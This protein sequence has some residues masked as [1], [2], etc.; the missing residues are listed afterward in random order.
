M[1]GARVE[2]RPVIGIT[3]YRER[4][5]WSYWHRDADVLP[6]AYA[7]AVADAGGSPLLIPS[8]PDAVLDSISRLDALVIS[9]G[10][11]VD[12]GL[13]HQPRHPAAGEPRRNRDASEIALLAAAVSAGKP[14][15]GICRGTQLLN[16]WCGGT[17]DQ[18]LPDD[19]EKLH[20]GANGAFA[21]RRVQLKEGSWLSSA[22]GETTTVSCHHHQA[23][24]VLGNGLRATAWAEDGVVEAVEMEGRGMV[25]GVQ[26]HPEEA[27]RS[28]L[29][30]AFVEHCRI[31]A[32][33]LAVSATAFRTG[34]SAS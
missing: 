5:Q 17:L 27:E 22:L 4:T 1:S 6:T 23:I 31:S 14:V 8:R 2:S 11:D 7:D 15:L 33:D 13:Y 30:G 26:W 9:G 28:S 16:V 29:F 3:A 12:S 21:P 18:H 24:R 32:R 20:H 10:P 34:G 25:Q 19:L